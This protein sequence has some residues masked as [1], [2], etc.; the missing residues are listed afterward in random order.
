MEPCQ[1]ILKHSRVDPKAIKVFLIALNC[2][3]NIRL[4]DKVEKGFPPS[5]MTFVGKLNKFQQGRVS[6]VRKLSRKKGF[7]LYKKP[8]SSGYFPWEIVAMKNLI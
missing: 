2:D 4:F 1:D 8:V 7:T 6:R 5:T 3:L